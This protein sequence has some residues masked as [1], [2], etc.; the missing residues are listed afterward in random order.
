MHAEDTRVSRSASPKKK[1]GSFSYSFDYLS[2]QIVDII[3]AYLLPRDLARC[4]YLSS[5]YH[6][7]TSVYIRVRIG[8]N[9][10]EKVCPKCGNDWI[11]T[12]PIDEFI[13]IDEDDHYFDVLYRRDYINRVFPA[14]QATRKHLLC[15]DC[16]NDI[17]ESTSVSHFV[18]RNYSTYQ[19]YVDLFSR[20]PWACLVK[21]ENTTTVWNQFRCVIPV[22]SGLVLEEDD[23]EDEER[24]DDGED[25][26]EDEDG[27]GEDDMDETYSDPEYEYDPEDWV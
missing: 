19:L 22:L 7:L 23:G 1:S 17:Q 25:E 18:L 4:L 2:S 5:C 26:D 11:S 16:E 14:E 13:D 15:D 10:L 6:K 9:L 21:H 3:L 8:V 24:D 20:Y 27:D 12:F